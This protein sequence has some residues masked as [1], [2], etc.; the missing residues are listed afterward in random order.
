MDY[1]RCDE[2]IDVAGRFLSKVQLG[3]DNPAVHL[4]NVVGKISDVTSLLIWMG[5]LAIVVGSVVVMA[6]QI[7]RLML[8]DGIDWLSINWFAPTDEVRSS[9]TLQLILLVVAMVVVRT[10]L[11]RLKRPDSIRTRNRRS[12]E[13]GP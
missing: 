2:A 3:V 13:G 12:N 8:G 7:A 1:L 6:D 9:P 5:G 11:I 10:T 4:R